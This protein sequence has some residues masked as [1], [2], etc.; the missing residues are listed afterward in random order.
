VVIA[1]LRALPIAVL[2]CALVAACAGKKRGTQSNVDAGTVDSATPS[3]TSSVPLSGLSATPSADQE[4]T[5]PATALDPVQV[6]AAYGALLAGRTDEARRLFAAFGVAQRVVPVRLGLRLQWVD[7]A[8]RGLLPPARLCAYGNLGRERNSEIM[9]RT[10]GG[11]G[12]NGELTAACP[13]L[14][15]DRQGNAVAQ[16]EPGEAQVVGQYL[17]TYAESGSTTIRDIADFRDR[18]V[19]HGEVVAALGEQLVVVTREAIAPGKSVLDRFEKAHIEAWLI[20]PVRKQ[21]AGPCRLSDSNQTSS[22]DFHLL[23]GGTRLLV[24]ENLPVTSVTLC[25]LDPARVILHSSI[26]GT[27]PWLTDPH[28]KTLYLSGLS[29]PPPLN[30]RDYKADLPTTEIYE[31]RQIDLRSG[32]AARARVKESAPVLVEHALSLS[33]DQQTLVVASHLQLAL[34]ATKPFHWLSSISLEKGMEG[35]DSSYNLTPEVRLLADGRSALAF[36]DLSWVTGFGQPPRKIELSLISL[37]KHRLELRGQLLGAVY[38]DKNMRHT[39]AVVDVAAPEPGIA[40]LTIDEQGKLTRRALAVGEGS[41]PGQRLPQ[42]LVGMTRLE[43]YPPAAP[44]G[45]TAI[46]QSLAPKLC[47]VGGLFVPRAACPN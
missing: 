29:L 33:D 44:D 15:F 31:H 10:S 5:P 40:L 35:F 3:A 1:V 21:T 16:F 25:G 41:D 7:G 34:F 9:T 12:P 13:E 26:S 18:F 20:D 43:L 2:A 4:P 46:A 23:A 39:G 6:R 8:P 28:E 42:E 32:V 47:W 17:V 27:K 30:G 38:Q 11:L 37:T 22:R 24:T 36:F 19:T 45:P 14:A